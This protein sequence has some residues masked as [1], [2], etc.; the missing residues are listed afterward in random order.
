[1]PSYKDMIL[2]QPII[3]VAGRV[4][5]TVSLTLYMH[6]G[7]DIPLVTIDTFWENL[8]FWPE[9]ELVLAF[10]SL[11]NPAYTWPHYLLKRTEEKLPTGNRICCNL[12]VTKTPSHQTMAQIQADPEEPEARPKVTFNQTPPPKDRRIL[13]KYWPMLYDTRYNTWNRTGEP[14]WEEC[15]YREHVLTTIE[16]NVSLNQRELVQRPIDCWTPW[17]GDRSVFSTENVRSENIIGWMELPE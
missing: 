9:N 5:D 17:T 4:S 15:I 3:Q 7:Y 6:K 10:G 2:R 13:L 16:W 1:M 14:K 11:D 12:A 8:K